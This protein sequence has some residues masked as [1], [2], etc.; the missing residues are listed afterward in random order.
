PLHQGS[1]RPY[2]QSAERVYRGNPDSC[3]GSAS[4]EL[5]SEPRSARAPTDRADS[6]PARPG[7]SGG[8]KHATAWLSPGLHAGNSQP[9]RLAQQRVRRTRAQRT[10]AFGGQFRDSNLLK[11]LTDLVGGLVANRFQSAVELPISLDVR[12]GSQAAD[13]TV[14]R[15]HYLKQGKIRGRSRET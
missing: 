14:H 12:E 15:L 3:G 1:P 7:A 6:F 2:T 9:T 5:P 8:W 10:L 13:R 4:S 11:D